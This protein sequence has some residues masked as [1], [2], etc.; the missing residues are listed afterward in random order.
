MGY[1][2][3]TTTSDGLA[4][5]QVLG[6]EAAITHI[7]KVEASGGRVLRITSPSGDEVGLE[8]FRRLVGSVNVRSI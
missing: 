1:K 7:S 8:E 6:P 5:F 2:I 3:E 4:E